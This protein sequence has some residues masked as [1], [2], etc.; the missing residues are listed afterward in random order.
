VSTQG[1]GWEQVLR[2]KRANQLTQKAVRQ[3]TSRR[4]GRSRVIAIL[5]IAAA[6]AFG[7]VLIFVLPSHVAGIILGIIV[8]ACAAFGLIYLPDLNP[9]KPWGN[10]NPAN[11]PKCGQPNLR[12]KRMELTRHTTSL[13]GGR[14]TSINTRTTTVTW[15]GIATLCTT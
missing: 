5:V 10:A 7:L 9:A 6:T 4:S 3:R 15:S 13:I 1:A 12:Q 8:L 11:C 2:E 14:G